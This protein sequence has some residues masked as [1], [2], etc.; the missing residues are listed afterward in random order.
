M[1]EAPPKDGGSAPAAQSSAH[2]PHPRNPNR[3]VEQPWEDED[4]LA[5]V[6]FLRHVGQNI[7]MEDWNRLAETVRPSF[8]LFP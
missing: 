5:L 6:D 2:H 7:E 3:G 8:F 4:E 1:G